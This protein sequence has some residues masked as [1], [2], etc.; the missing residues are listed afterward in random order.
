MSKLSVEEIKDQSRSLRGPIDQ[1]LK[2]GVD[3]FTEE[4]Y[5]SSRP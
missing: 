2:S 4:E 5:Q 3:H 1:T